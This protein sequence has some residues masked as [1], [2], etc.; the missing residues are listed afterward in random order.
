V[1]D[2]PRAARPPELNFDYHIHTIYSGHSGPEMFLPAVMAHC[3]ERGAR[4]V[5]IL[6]HV[7]TMSSETYVSVDEWLAGRNDR[8]A[9]EAIISEVG[10]RRAQFPGTEFLIGAEIDADPLRLD[11]SLMLDDLSGLDAVLASAHVLPG[12]AG[13]WFSPPALSAEER[14]EFRE[15]WLA[16][17]ENVAANP[18]VN[19]LAH[20]LSEMDNCGLTAGF[21]AEFREA[22]R[23]LL[24]AM[25]S[26]GVAFE[27]NESALGRLMPDSLP[28]FVELVRL[29]KGAGTR[30]TVGTDAHLGRQLGGYALIAEVIAAAGLTA[31]DFWH[32]GA[33]PDPG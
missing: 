22:C 25:A 19:I 14:R 9:L 24:S 11:G 5:L 7:P 17:L 12:G 8:T 28:G 23:P 20:P 33:A 3:A 31:D 2:S 21:D 26:A 15:R 30:F 6:E 4:R 13:F 10:P 16:W 18:R 27:L 32:P 29:A 1:T